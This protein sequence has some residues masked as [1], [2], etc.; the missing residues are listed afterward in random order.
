MSSRIEVILDKADPERLLRFY[1]GSYV[2][3]GGADPF[4]AGLLSREGDR[5]Y[6]HP[7]V[8]EAT[9]VGLG[10]DL[11]RRARG[12]RLVWDSLS[13]FLNATY[14]AAR[15]LP[16]T[17]EAF[18]ASRP[19]STWLSFNVD[20]PM[21]RARRRIYVE[22]EALREALA[23]YVERGERL[24]YPSGAAIVGEHLVDGEHIETTA[25][26]RRTDGFWDFLTYGSDGRL[27]PRTRA[28]PRALDTPTQCVGCHFGSKKFEPERSF[29]QPAAPGPDGPR[30]YYVEEAANAD[31]VARFFKE[32]ARRSDTVLGI[33]ATIFVSRLRAARGKGRL[34][35]QDEQLLG[36]LGL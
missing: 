35:E 16:P 34:S 7:S 1:F 13:V 26:L 15:R 4:E 21:T 22:E 18:R 8:L 3:D 5:F 36:Y 33:Y 10:Q 12:G 9:R 19:Y 28:L 30:A 27:A 23:L 31:E 14:Y 6:A 32:H 29:P 20:G 2:S 24:V 11:A 17:L 25:M